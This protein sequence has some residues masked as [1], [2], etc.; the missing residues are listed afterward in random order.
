MWPPPKPPDEEQRLKITEEGIILGHRQ[1]IYM[2][3]GGGE[4]LSS[5]IQ[6]INLIS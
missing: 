3:W 4:L 1:D 2:A 6:D 5:R